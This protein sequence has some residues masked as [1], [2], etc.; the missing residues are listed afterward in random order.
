MVEADTMKPGS[1]TA[2]YLRAADG[3]D[4]ADLN[5]HDV[6][7]SGDVTI[8]GALEGA[9]LFIP[10]GGSLSNTTNSR[11]MQFGGAWLNG[12]DEG[13]PMPRD[14]S[15]VSYTVMTNI[16]SYT[17]VATMKYE[18]RVN[19]S[20]VWNDTK[21]LDATGNVIWY[22]TQARGT[23]TFS[24]GDYITTRMDVSGTLQ[25]DSVFA[26]FEVVFDD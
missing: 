23:D 12:T 19:G 2:Y 22:A 5:V 8:T 18:I 13:M 26:G 20:V 17:P 4:D 10:S 25:Y 14:G 21:T 7:A 24:A 11:Y 3:Q 15:I 6:S 9:R 16:D 1:G